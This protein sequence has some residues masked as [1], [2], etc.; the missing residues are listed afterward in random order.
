[1]MMKKVFLNGFV[2]L[3]AAT[4]AVNLRTFRSAG[5]FEL[6]ADQSSENLAFSRSEVDARK[7]ITIKLELHGGFVLRSL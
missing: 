3:M 1:M 2:I 4:V 5:R 7:P 6:I